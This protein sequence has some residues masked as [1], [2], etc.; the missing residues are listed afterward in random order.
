MKLYTKFLVPYKTDNIVLCKIPLSFM[1]ILNGV[2]YNVLTKV[3]INKYV[4]P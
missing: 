1:S 2:L 4:T 3:V